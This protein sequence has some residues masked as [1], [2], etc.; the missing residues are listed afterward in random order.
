MKEYEIDIFNGGAEKMT[1]ILE[2]LSSLAHDEKLLKFIGDKALEQVNALSIERLS[3]ISSSEDVL[4]S[5]YYK[6]NKIEIVDDTLYIYN[7]SEIDI[8]TKIMNPEKRINYP[9]KIS[10]AKMVEYGIGY[11]GSTTQ[12]V[13]DEEW[14]YD[15]NNHGNKGWYYIDKSGV[16]HWTNGYQGR[17]IYYNLKLI[18]ENKVVDWI[19]QY[20][21]KNL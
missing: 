6:N 5:E 4:A 8:S 14:K 1:S 2:K 21:N 10:L 12:N 15:V 16:K 19:C 20:L 18:I 7:D 13:E 3:T 11:T 17:L 9:L